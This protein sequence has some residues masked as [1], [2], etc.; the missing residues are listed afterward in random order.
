[1][2]ALFASDPNRLSDW[3]AKWRAAVARLEK[4]RAAATDGVS[5]CAAG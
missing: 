2:D 4:R 1:M 3:G 5:R